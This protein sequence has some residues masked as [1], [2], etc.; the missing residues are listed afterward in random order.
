[1]PGIND[2]KDMK[3]SRNTGLTLLEVMI[4]SIILTAI[5][6]MT[7]QILFRGTATAANGQIHSQLQVRGREFTDFCKGEL[8]HASLREKGTTG[9]PTQVLGIHGNHTIL[10]YRVPVRRDRT[11]RIDFG[12]RP[13]G[14]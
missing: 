14:P 10:H 3:R 5:L 7:Y 2:M 11:G 1:M 4:S 12:Y 9:L 8:L 6:L 13:N